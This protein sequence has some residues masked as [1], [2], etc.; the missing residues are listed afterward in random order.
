MQ[1]S[2]T[3][4]QASLSPLFSISFLVIIAILDVELACFNIPFHAMINIIF[5]WRLSFVSAHI[6]Q[7]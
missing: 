7:W 1:A 2:F 4:M 5:V 6:L 3:P